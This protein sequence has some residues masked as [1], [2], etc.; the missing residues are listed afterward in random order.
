[1][2][3]YKKST[4]SNDA[5]IIREAMFANNKPQEKMVKYAVTSSYEDLKPVFT[6]DKSDK[7]ISTKGKSYKPIFTKDKGVPATNQTGKIFS[8]FDIQRY[9][10]D[11]YAIKTAFSQT[12]KKFAVSVLTNHAFLGTV[13]W[14]EYWFYE[15]NEYDKAKKTYDK[16]N[17]VVEEVTTQFVEA[18]GA[19]PTP[20]FWTFLK[21]E[22]EKIDPKATIRSN[23]PYVN[24]AKQ[25]A[26]I[27]CPDWRSNIYG[28]RYPTYR[29]ESFH[30]YAKY[31]KKLWG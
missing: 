17:K 10:F 14:D 11:S 15:L 6:N 27:S 1:M 7:P 13:T 9:V 19:L 3:W 20:M 29:E 16:L 4:I 21:K 31:R 22:A 12:G 2:N 8:M 18:D 25:Y 26:G 24:Y 28:T 30:S 5:K 23:I